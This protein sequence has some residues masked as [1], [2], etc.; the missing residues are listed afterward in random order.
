MESSNAPILSSPLSNSTGVPVRFA[1]KTPLAVLAVLISAGLCIAVGYAVGLRAPQA[2]ITDQTI[3][4]PI[5][6]PMAVQSEELGM[7]L[8]FPTVRTPKKIDTTSWLSHQDPSGYRLSYPKTWFIAGEGS[9][10]QNW[11]PNS[12]VR[13]GPLSGDQTKWDISFLEGDASSFEKSVRQLDASVEQW[14]SVE[15]SQTRDGWPVTFFYIKSTE[16][17]GGPYLA[18]LIRTPSNKTLTFR[19]FFG[20]EQSENVEVLKQIVE[21][22]QKSP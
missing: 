18:A 21:S 1:N 7:E 13:P 15:V 8:P 9:Q 10:V 17:F 2:V 6:S 22:I 12:V 14:D 19:G 11:D 20:M 16:P 4:S 5:P 3:A